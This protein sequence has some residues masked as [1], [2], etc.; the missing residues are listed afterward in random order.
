MGVSQKLEK[1]INYIA[2]VTGLP[3]WIAKIEIADEA[4][5]SVMSDL[6]DEDM[7]KMIDL[8][9]KYYPSQIK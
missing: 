6:S 5:V 1:C 4:G 9:E 3:Y 2:E 8:F 7:N